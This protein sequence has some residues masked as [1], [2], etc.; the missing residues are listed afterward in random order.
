[1]NKA[2]SLKKFSHSRH[3][4]NDGIRNNNNTNANTNAAYQYTHQRMPSTGSISS[5]GVKRAPS[6]SNNPPISANNNNNNTTSAH[7]R[8]SSVNSVSSNLLAEQYDRDRN[9]I[10]SSCFNKKLDPKTGQPILTYFTHVRIIEDSKYPSSRPASNSSLTNK[11]KRVLI[12]SANN[13]TNQVF[14]NKARENHDHTFQIGRTWSLKELTCLESDP[15]VPEGFVFTMT[16]KYYW[17]TNTAKERTIFTKTLVKIYMDYFEGRVPIL[18][19]WDLSMFYLDERSYERAVIHPNE[20]IQTK[21]RLNN[22]MKQQRHPLEQE[23]FKGQQMQQERLRQQDEQSRKQQEDRLRQQQQQEQLRKQQEDRLRQQQQEE[24]EQLRK[25]QE[26]RLRQQQQQQQQEQLRK[27][28]EDRLRQQQEDRLR[29]QQEEQS[30]KQQQP[31]P[32]QQPY[33]HMQ[34]SQHS[35]SSSNTMNSP[36]GSQTPIVSPKNVLDRS[37]SVTSTGSFVFTDQQQHRSS[38]SSSSHP[39][40]NISRQSTQRINGSNNNLAGIVN[41]DRKSVV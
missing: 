14:L 26:D 25:Q 9:S 7:K 37:A 1:M 8:N 35:I 19:N 22:G 10:I 18:I 30:R 13:Q 41:T 2:I 23:Q 11:K 4:Q 5:Y 24:E 36:S 34:T 3:T 17:E 16:K 15:M 20:S 29:Q 31:P 27:Q 32:R 39:Y 33:R 40:S 21:P 38:F 6:H 12:V 28:Q